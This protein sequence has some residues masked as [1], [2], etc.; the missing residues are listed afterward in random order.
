MT[1]YA[2]TTCAEDWKWLL[3]EPELHWRSGYSAMAL[4][5]CWEAARGLPP[6]I[7]ELFT[8]IGP[9]PTLLLAVPEHKVPL[10][11]A[12]RG[13]SQN[14]L[15]SLVRTSEH[16][17]AVTIE[18]KVNE[19]F[20]RTLGEWLK[21]ASTGKLERLEYICSLLGLQQPLPDHIHYQL[22]HRT[23]SALIEADRFKTDAAAMV[24]HSFSQSGK[25]FAEFRQFAALLGCDL[26]PGQ[27]GRATT[28]TKRPLFVGWA[29]GNE[30]FLTVPGG[31]SIGGDMIIAERVNEYV[32]KRYP[33]AIC[34]ACVAKA[35]KLRHQQ[36][37][38]VTMALGT[39]S[40]FDRG[41]GFCIACGKDQKVTRRL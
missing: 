19:A 35:L 29:V 9:S 33:E 22:L 24:V 13:D 12:K 37:N 40:D 27:L 25:W 31:G 14:D 7:G 34:D 3:A 4:A 36:A 41:G 1:I 17:V 20:D 30:R 11:G 6:E 38:R 28:A 16:T 18:G 8:A 23:A 10:P 26:S 21:G 15:F 32:T 2:P 5:R 39:T